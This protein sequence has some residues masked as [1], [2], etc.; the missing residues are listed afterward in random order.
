MATLYLAIFVIGFALTMISFLTGV[1]SHSFGHFGDVGH[2]GDAGHGADT[3]DAHGDHGQ[4]V[5]F[6]NF[7]TITAF[8]MWFGGIGFLVATYSQ[9]VALGTVVLALGGGLGGAAI[10][11]V[12]MAKVLAP[13]QIPLNPADYY[14]PG[15]LGRVTVTIPRDG[16]GE[17]VYTQVGTRKTVAGRAADGAEIAKGTEVVVLRYERGIAYARPWD[18][19]ADER[20]GRPKA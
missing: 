2:G 7:G 16:T 18:Q 11:F 19:V 8:M 9:L 17:I 20:S 12:F 10:I 15:T 4:R 3:G 6:V 1:A 5:P 14:L 13:D